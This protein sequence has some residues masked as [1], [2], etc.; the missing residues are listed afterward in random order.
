MLLRAAN[1]QY[2]IY[3]LLLL[4]KI[5]TWNR[6][7]PNKRRPLFQPERRRR[8]VTQFLGSGCFLYFSPDINES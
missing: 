1:G 3:Y 4:R 5:N 7:T 8:A 6:K 2:R